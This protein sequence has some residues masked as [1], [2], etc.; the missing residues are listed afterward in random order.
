[1]FAKSQKGFTLIELLIYTGIFSVV[2]G[3]MT[4]ILTTTIKINQREASSNEVTSQ[5]NFVMQTIQRL[6]KESSIIIVNSTS[7]DYN[8]DA[9]I[10]SPQSR[11]VLRMK[12]SGGAP[13]TDRDPI[14]IY[15]SSSTIKMSQGSGANQII[16]DLTSNRVVVDQLQFT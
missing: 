6:T 10:G 13:T 16:S 7:T 9:T 5:L 2:A 11:L 15:T 4:G 14:T 1:M 12:D 8:N 3:L